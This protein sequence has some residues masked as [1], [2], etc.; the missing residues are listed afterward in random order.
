MGSQAEDLTP[1]SQGPE[2]TLD[3]KPSEILDEK[4]GSLTISPA[5]KHDTS[6][7]EKRT[8]HTI[9]KS[10]FGENKTKKTP[11]AHGDSILPGWTIMRPLRMKAMGRAK[12]PTEN[13]NGTVSER[14]SGSDEGGNRDIKGVTTNGTASSTGDL[15]VLTTMRSDD[16]LLDNDDDA[17]REPTTGTDGVV[18]KVY[19]RRWFGLVQLVL[20]NIIVSWDVSLH[21]RLDMDGYLHTGC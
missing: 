21:K 19:K 3:V 2:R 18:Y 6:S 13:G 14:A 8:S 16:D 12:K 17:P 4:D 5:Q 10:E 15:E 1:I 11:K 9:E 20:L 7:D